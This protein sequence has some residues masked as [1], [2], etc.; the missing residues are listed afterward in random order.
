[1]RS[2]LRVSRGGLRRIVDV[3]A[4]P[5]RLTRATTLDVEGGLQYLPTVT[6]PTGEVHCGD[7]RVG[8]KNL[9]ELGAAGHLADR[10]DAAPSCCIRKSGR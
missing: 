7:L 5:G 4:D 3:P 9:V 10:N 2:L 6:R 1:M 8:E